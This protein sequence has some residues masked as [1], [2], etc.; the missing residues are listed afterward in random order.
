[1]RHRRPTLLLLGLT[2]C[3]GSVDPDATEA[4]TWH[5]DIQPI[6][7]AH[8][9]ECHAAGG[10]APFVLDSYEAVAEIAP[11]IKASVESRSMPPWGASPGDIEMLFDISLTDAQVAAIADWVDADTPEGDPASPGDPITLDLGGLPSYDIELSVEGGYTST[12]TPGEDEYRC[13]VLD[14]PAEEDTFVTGIEFIAGNP[15][16]DHHAVAYAIPPHSVDKARTFDTWDDGPGYSCFGTAA[17]SDFESNPLAGEFFDQRFVS[18]WA[19]GISGVEIGQGK[20]GVAIQPGSVIVLQMHYS[21][22]D[23]GDAFDTSRVRFRTSDAVEAEGFYMP[24]MN[25]AWTAVPGMMDIPAD[26]EDIVVSYRAEAVSAGNATVLGADEEMVQDG[27]RIHTTFAH[28]HKLGAGVEYLLHRSDGTTMTLLDAD[29]YDFNWQREYIYAEPVDIYPGDE[30]EVRCTYHNTAEWRAARG[31]Y[32]PEPVD[33]T[34]GDGTGDEMCVA[35]SL[36]SAPQ[37]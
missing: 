33:V 17:H 32:P 36:I 14:W 18:A 5:G 29:R 11:L 28:M 3:A 35:H 10:V 30:L 9:A 8:C 34:W 23:G 31:A 12:A 26:Q 27:F 25:L 7:E 1:M 20:L 15:A 2:A 13:F 22:S 16:I 21:N 6:I 24:W 19:P 4:P 37:P